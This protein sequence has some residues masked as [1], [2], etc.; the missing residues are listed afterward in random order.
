MAAP[1]KTAAAAAL[2]PGVASGRPAPAV[3]ILAAI[4][5][6]ATLASTKRAC[7][8]WWRWVVPPTILALLTALHRPWRL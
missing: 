7:S 1:P 4:V 6:P 2:S 3:A 5:L 8:V